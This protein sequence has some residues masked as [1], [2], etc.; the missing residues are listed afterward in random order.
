MR[1]FVFLRASLAA[2]LDP[3]QGMDEPART[4]LWYH[5]RRRRLSGGL[6]G[7]PRPDRRTDGQFH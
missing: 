5:L 4:L 3:A 2:I 1:P 6:L 7:G